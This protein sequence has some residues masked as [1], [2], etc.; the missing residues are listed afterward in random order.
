MYQLTVESPAAGGSCPD[1]GSRPDAGR[2][3]VALVCSPV[4]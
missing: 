4:A 1:A 3:P 2:Y